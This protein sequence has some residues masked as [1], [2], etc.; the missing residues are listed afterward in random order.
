MARLIPSV[1]IDS[2]ANLPERDVARALVEGLGDGCLIYH[3]YPWL[4]PERDHRGQEKYLREGEADF[5]V[6]IPERGMLVLEV[7]GGDIQYD[8]DGHRWFRCM[9]RGELK[10]LNKDP[11]R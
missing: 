7:K 8:A 1:D 2:I 3:S 4:R 6:L 5:V 9:P 10:D 11:F